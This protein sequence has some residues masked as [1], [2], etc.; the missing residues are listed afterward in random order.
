MPPLVPHAVSHLHTFRNTFGDDLRHLLWSA[1]PIAPRCHATFPPPRQNRCRC[2]SA[3]S[4]TRRVGRMRSP[5]RSSC[6]PCSPAPVATTLP[7]G[8]VRQHPHPPPHR[9]LPPPPT[10]SRRIFHPCAASPP[11]HPIAPSFPGHATC[12]MY[13]SPGARHVPTTTR[14]RARSAVPAPAPPPPPPRRCVSCNFCTQTLPCPPMLRDTGTHPAHA[15][16]CPGPTCPTPAHLLAISARIARTCNLLRTP[17][18][19]PRQLLTTRGGRK[20]RWLVA[21]TTCPHA[22]AGATV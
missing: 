12:C 11:S 7:R 9:R 15:G 13:A 2:P 5:P 3:P 1:E 14:A 17:F 6:P 16:F 20:R 4:R 8:S 18:L 22:A 19:P 21:S 10:H